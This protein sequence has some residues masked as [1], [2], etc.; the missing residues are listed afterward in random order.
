MIF[1]ITLPNNI[2]PGEDDNTSDYV[3]EGL[4]K[5]LIHSSRIA[6]A[7]PMDYER[8]AILCGRQHGH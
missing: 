7:D 1:L 8:A 2:F 3:M 4:M 5:S 6:V